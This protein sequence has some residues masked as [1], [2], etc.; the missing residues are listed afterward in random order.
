MNP[1]YEYFLNRSKKTTYL[2]KIVV[3]EEMKVQLIFCYYY[4][5]FYI[6]L[7]IELIIEWK[8]IIA[9]N[10]L[11]K[12]QVSIFNRLETRRGRPRW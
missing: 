4:L 12:N 5:P 8:Y 2:E 9:L 7:I 11:S 10:T 3:V 6:A 1:K